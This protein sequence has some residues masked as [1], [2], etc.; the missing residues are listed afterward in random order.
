MSSEDVDDEPN[1]GG[2]DSSHT[3]GEALMRMAGMGGGPKPIKNL[4]L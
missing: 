2:N 1:N 3:S 4:K